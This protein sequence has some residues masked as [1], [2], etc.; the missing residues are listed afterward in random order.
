M[1]YPH[2]DRHFYQDSLVCP[3]EIVRILSSPLNPRDR[4]R[5]SPIKTAWP[6]EEYL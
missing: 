2:L 1:S 5:C 6:K 4:W 3:T